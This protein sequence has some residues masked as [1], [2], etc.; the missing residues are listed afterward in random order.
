MENDEIYYPLVSKSV[1]Q[2]P[3]IEILFKLNQ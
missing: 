2:V 3:V 1:P